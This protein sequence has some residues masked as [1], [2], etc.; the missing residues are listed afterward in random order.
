MGIPIWYVVMMGKP[1]PNYSFMIWQ[2]VK[3]IPC[4]LDDVDRLWRDEA[5]PL[6]NQPG[7]QV[8]VLYVARE[9]ESPITQEIPA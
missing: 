5:Q 3:S 4:T 9:V 1:G 7:G 2:V 8:Q 6:L